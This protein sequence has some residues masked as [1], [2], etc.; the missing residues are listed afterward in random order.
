MKLL[1]SLL[2]MLLLHYLGKLKIASDL[3]RRIPQTHD[4]ACLRVSTGWPQLY[5]GLNLIWLPSIVLP[6]ALH[7]HAPCHVTYD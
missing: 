5:D 1:T 4:R 3:P 7:A 2:G 6:A